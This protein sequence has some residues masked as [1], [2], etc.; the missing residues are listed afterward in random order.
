LIMI[1]MRIAIPHWQG[2]VSPV[3]DES[4]QLL[5]VDILNNGEIRY[6]EKRLCN[7]DPLLRAK[8]VANSGTEVLICGA[9]SLTLEMAL[10]SEN[11]NVI[12]CTCGPVKDVIEAFIDDKLSDPLFLMPGCCRKRRSPGNSSRRNLR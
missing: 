1:G 8:D 10:I 9:V 4:R 6:A 12:P 5:L 11:I 2:R 3:F 7:R